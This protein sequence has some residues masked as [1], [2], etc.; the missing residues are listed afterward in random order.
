MSYYWG[1][2]NCKSDTGLQVESFSKEIL[3]FVCWRTSFVALFKSSQYIHVL[4]SK[5]TFWTKLQV[6]SQLSQF[7]PNQFKP[8]QLKQIQFNSIQI[9]SHWFKSIQFN[10]IQINSIQFN[11]NQSNFTSI[12]IEFKSTQLHAIQSIPIQ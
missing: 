3:I 12:Q 7:K 8:S 2:S 11:A 9:N 5:G 10:S 6:N 1:Y 4:C